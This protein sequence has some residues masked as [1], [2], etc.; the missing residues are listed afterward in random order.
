M[1]E[2]AAALT[3]VAET[4][5]EA[6]A[7][8]AASA[9]PPAAPDATA[10]F[11]PG[12]TRLESPAPAGQTV[13][14]SPP[15]PAPADGLKV[16]LVEPSRTQAGIIRRYL[17]GQGVQQV[18]TAAT[19]KEAL[20][21]VRRERPTA[22]VS[23]LYLADMNGVQLAQQIRQ[24]N[25]A[26]APGFILISSESE[27]AEAGSLSQCGRAHHL[28]KP[29]TPEDLA[30]A[31]KL[32]SAGPPAAAADR[33]KLRVLVVDDSTP[34][35]M[36]VRSVLQGLGLTQFAEAADGAQAVAAIAREN[37]DLIVTDYN[38]PF[39]DGRAL[40]AYLKQNPATAALPVIMVTTEQ[41][42]AKLEAVRRLGV[43]AVCDKSFPADAVRGVLDRLVTKS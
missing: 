34:A 13:D 28:R 2:V 1:A 39:L 36:H 6:A 43:A 11:A 17:Q 35:R 29:F 41:D 40:I 27:S 3:A 4:L 42:P 10:Y 5:G 25:R 23:T 8:R 21:L 16:L 38:M 19:G 20:E 33:S 9:P 22:V 37:F 24:D 26:G 32:V 7:A 15:R 18:V 31:L 14:L 30:T 12:S